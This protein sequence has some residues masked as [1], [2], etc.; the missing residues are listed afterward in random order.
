[1]IYIWLGSSHF[2]ESSEELFSFRIMSRMKMRSLLKIYRTWIS[3]HHIGE[4]IL[5]FICNLRSCLTAFDCTVMMYF[6][7][8]EFIFD[9]WFLTACFI[10]LTR[11]NCF[12]FNW[13]YMENRAGFLAVFFIFYYF[14]VNPIQIGRNTIFFW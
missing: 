8:I 10:L 11:T 9:G 2:T 4:N 13:N 7:F 1:M 5:Y 12:L 6:C 14:E 3:L